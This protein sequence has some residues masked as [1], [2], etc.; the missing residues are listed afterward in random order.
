MPDETRYTYLK[1]LGPLHVEPVPPHHLKGERVRVC[2]IMGPTGS[3][4]SA[5][6]EALALEKALSISGDS[7]DGVTKHV[8]C[9]RVKNLQDGELPVILMDTPGL[10]DPCISESRV[11]GMIS[12]ELEVLRISVEMAVVTLC[13]FH[14]IDVPR[15]GATRRGAVKF[16]QGFA[17]TFKANNVNVVTTMWNKL[18]NDKL[19]TAAELRFE[20]LKVEIYKASAS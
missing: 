4:K 6:I 15:M 13:Y 16:L 5:F 20:A 12:K 7:L 10:L 18:W 11:V 19:S 8:V 14:P 9:Y 2:I 17:Q 3:G 1:V